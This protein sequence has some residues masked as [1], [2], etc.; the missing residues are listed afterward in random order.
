MATEWIRQV[1]VKPDGVYLH[2]KSNNDDLPYRVWKSDSL[3]ETYQNEGHR[4]LDREVVRMLCEYAEIKGNHPSMTRYR[5]CLREGLAI[6]EAF[7]Q[8]I[9]QAYQKMTSK[10]I[11]SIWFTDDKPTAGAKEYHAFRREAENE[12]YTKLADLA[13]ALPVKSPRGTG[14][15]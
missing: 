9:K 7:H 15:R 5:P 3:T 14:A 6:R 11:A 13:V 10:D 2:S 12:L 8:S 1:I 4:G